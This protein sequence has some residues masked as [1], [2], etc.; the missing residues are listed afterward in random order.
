MA[1]GCLRWAA[2]NQTAGAARNGFVLGS[3]M[4]DPHTGQCVGYE[5]T[6]VIRTATPAPGH[7]FGYHVAGTADNDCI[8]DKHV[9]APHLVFVCSVALVT[10]TRL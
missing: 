9:F 1:L 10:V 6:G 2:Q 3:S 7:L 5:R 4:A 8:A